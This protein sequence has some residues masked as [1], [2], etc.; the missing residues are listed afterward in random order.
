MARQIA[1]KAKYGL[2]VKPAE[3]AAMERVLGGCESSPALVDG[4]DA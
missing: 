4:G 2:W 3:A 1:V